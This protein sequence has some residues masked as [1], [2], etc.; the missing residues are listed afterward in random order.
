M[1]ERFKKLCQFCFAIVVFCKQVW[2]LVKDIFGKRANEN[3]PY[4][5]LAPVDDAS[6]IEKHIKA[7]ARFNGHQPS[8]YMNETPIRYWDDF[9]FG[10][11]RLQGDTFPHYWSCLTARSYIDY[12]NASGDETYKLAAEECIRN[13]FCLFNEKGEGSCA[14]VYPYR[15]NDSKGEFYDTWANDQDFALYFYKTLFE[16]KESSNDI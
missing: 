7:L 8:C 10:S 11:G 5:D 15:V 9:W 16:G 13:C 3:V 2:R 6:G 12:Y 1:K 4:K 14:Y